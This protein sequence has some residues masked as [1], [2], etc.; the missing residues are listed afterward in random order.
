MEPE[1][2]DGRHP[3]GPARE[4]WIYITS[5]GIAEIDGEEF[6]VASGDYRASRRQEVEIYDVSD[7][8]VPLEVEPDPTATT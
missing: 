3:S 6:E 1:L 5:R 8:R 7:A 2:G 4:E